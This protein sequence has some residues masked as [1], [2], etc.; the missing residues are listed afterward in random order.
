MSPRGETGRSQNRHCPKA[1]CGRTCVFR[2]VFLWHGSC[3]DL[4]DESY[5]ENGWFQNAAVAPLLGLWRKRG[6]T[7]EGLRARG[8]PG[9]TLS[10]AGPGQ[11]Q[12]VNG[13]RLSLSHEAAVIAEI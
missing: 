1:G 5:R 2:D 7:F 8:W 9:A 13:W 4:Q 11:P 12:I 6:T 10:L 3:P